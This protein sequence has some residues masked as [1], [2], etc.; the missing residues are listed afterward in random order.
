MNASTHNGS[1]SYAFLSR[2]LGVL[3]LV[4]AGLKVDGLAVD[5]LAQDSFLSSPR[6]QIATIQAEIL[7]GLW[8]LSGWSA[9]ASW[10]AALVFF[11]A[12][13]GTSLY[14]A[15]VG[16]ASCGCFGRVL[17]SPWWSFGLDAAV[18]AALA[19]FRP[20][21]ETV[22]QPS[23]ALR[24]V[25]PTVAGAAA[26]LALIAGG[27]F[28]WF[29][30]PEEALAR[31]R[32]EPLTVEPVVSSVGEGV[33]GEERPFTIRLKNNSDRSIRVIGGTTTCAC[34]ASRSL[35]ITLAPGQSDS[36]EVVMRFTG[37]PGR[38]QHRFILHTDYDEQRMITA[39][40]AGRVVEPPA[41]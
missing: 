8:L 9:R 36:I 1:G 12:L 32:G 30:N 19:V 39:R 28:L 3:L 29:D 31:L 34:I 15:L 13:G 25:M 27:F 21:A 11:G 23:A 41:Q 6:L 35:P 18:L 4:A 24:G 37:S 40:F 20:T 16:Q 10:V 33:G 5:P 38:F 22:G 7:L 17:V 26:F 2:I 14:L